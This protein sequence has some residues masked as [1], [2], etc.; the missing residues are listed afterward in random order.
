MILLFFICVIVLIGIFIL[1]AGSL[2][3]HRSIN[4]IFKGMFGW[5]YYLVKTL[6]ILKKVFI[7]AI[8]YKLLKKNKE[9][10]KDK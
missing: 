9:E 2:M 1:L 3:I 7:I 10:K 8:L 4:M 5:I 6:A